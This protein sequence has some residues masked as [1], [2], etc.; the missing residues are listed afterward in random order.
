MGTVW[1]LFGHCM[2]TVRALAQIASDAVRSKL[3][4]KHAADHV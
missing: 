1:A 2:G 3:S 4:Y